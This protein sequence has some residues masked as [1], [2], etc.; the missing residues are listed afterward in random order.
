MVDNEAGAD[1]LVAHL[2]RLGHRRIATITGPMEKSTG[3]E[4]L[5]GYQRA[6]GIPQDPKLVKMGDFRPASGYNLALE[7]LRQ[8]A[9][10]GFTALFVANNAM[11]TGAIN[12]IRELRRSVPDEL[13]F[14]IFDDPE[15]ARLV[16]PAVTAMQQPAYRMG[17][18]A[19]DL[20]LRKLRGG[21]RG[22]TP[23][24]IKLQPNLVIRHS[25]GETRP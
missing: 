19:A 11:A 9:A 23:G 21:R 25:C 3:S 20:L 1:E 15:W 12:A 2:I 17:S 7:L 22:D 24:A 8:Q 13:A 10:L 14:V 6:P 4:R 5:R 18:L 16:D